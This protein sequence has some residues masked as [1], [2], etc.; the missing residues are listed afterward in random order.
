MKSLLTLFTLSGICVSAFGQNVGIGTAVP[1]AK[2]HV[3]GTF[4]LVDGTE[5]A[6]EVLTSDANG[7]ASWQPVSGGG[8]TLDYAYD[9]GGPGVGSIIT[10]D[11][12]AFS[13]FGTDGI[14]V[15]GTYG[16]GA[17]IGS[18]GAGTR[19]FFNPRKAAFRAGT[20]PGAQWN[21]V[22]VG[23]YSSAF[24]YSTTASADFSVAM[25][26]FNTASG[27]SSM[28]MGS[29]TTASGLFS[30]ALGNSTIASGDYSTAFGDQTT[31]Y[32]IN[33][34][35]FGDQTTAQGPGST[36]MGNFTIAAGDYSTG[37]GYN[38]DATGHYSTS[39]GVNNWA[40]G[41]KST[42]MGMATIASGEYSTAMGFNTGAVGNYSTALGKGTSAIGLYST[43]MGDAAFANGLNATAMGSGTFS[44][45]TSS[46]A[47]GANT[48]AESGYETAIGRWN[49]DYIPASPAGWDV[50][51]RLFVVGNGTA[52]GSRS[53]AMVILKNGNTGMGVSSPSQKLE[54]G[55]TS[56][57]L[58]MNS[59]TSN[60]LVFNQA[61][62]NM[63]TTTTRSAGTKIVFYPQV[64]PT[65]VDYA[66]GINGYTLWY[67]VPEANSS[68]QH[69]FYGGTSPL[70]TIRGDGYVGIGTTTP[71]GHFDVDG[72][73]D[74][75]LA[76]DPNAGTT[77]SLF[78]P[79]HTYISPYNGSNI[80]YLQARRLNDAGT[81]ALRLRTS[82]AGVVTE[83]VHVSGA[84]DVG[85]GTTNPLAK[86]HVHGTNTWEEAYTLYTNN[87]TGSSL[88]DG[89]II[90]TTPSGAMVWNLEATPLSFLT[91]S[92]ERMTILSGGNV[93]IGTTAPAYTLEVS[94]TAAK[95]GGGSWI[96][97]SDSRL[98]QNVAPYTD[99][100]TEVLSIKPMRYNYN[101]LSGHDTA[102]TYVGVIAQELQ[103]IVPYMVGTFDKEGEE[104]LNV[105]NSAMIYM[106]INAVQELS[107]LNDLQQAEISE[108]KE[109]LG[110]EVLKN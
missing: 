16:V 44:S 50:A 45:G 39:L 77:Q 10:A 53:D 15:T 99:G 58:Y 86:Q 78:I 69:Q 98:K 29:S 26:A 54:I 60:H 107:A 95:P 19:M 90:G 91:S 20:V 83:A 102:L 88:G 103:E 79:G 68:Y 76:D 48:S 11:A 89:F 5:G 61:G 110:L 38:D 25:G 94:N 100:L 63:P 9:F 36:A 66:M 73:G 35:A 75:Y 62:V 93:G 67:S 71:R 96:A 65:E 85:I 4:R 49:T 3:S 34:T 101:S 37:L 17:A 82:N 13:V 14:R 32:G 30:V 104:Y 84:G 7:N 92:I 21:E 72:A 81:V 42:A 108:L 46:T 1:S 56:S 47:M 40:S 87:T 97:T 57:Q 55:G 2:L 64:S 12:G 41:D 33:S 31:A 70:M 105:D 74:I 109:R 27:N 28:A 22:S 106:L 6:G 18:P 52:T 43:A 8:G 51:D 80:A 59:G 23:N 24:G